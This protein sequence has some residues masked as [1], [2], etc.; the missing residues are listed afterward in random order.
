MNKEDIPAASSGRYAFPRAFRL[1]GR[2][3]PAIINIRKAVAER[4]SGCNG[5]GGMEEIRDR[6]LNLA[7]DMF[8]CPNRCRHCWLGRMLNKIMPDGSD[9]R[10]MDCFSPFF[11]RIA[12][13]SWLREP[14]FCD[15][16]RERWER[17]IPAELIPYI[18]RVRQAPGGAGMYRCSGA[19]CFPAR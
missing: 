14:D 9:Q 16:C 3:R 19:G 17:D 12:F 18:S 10:I 15:S 11:D 13:C 8:G 4:P 7:A 1:K 2:S 5:A 6:Q